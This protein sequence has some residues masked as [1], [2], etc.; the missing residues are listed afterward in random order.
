MGILV[1][2]QSRERIIVD[3]SRELGSMKKAVVRIL[4][5]KV[6]LA[7]LSTDRNPSP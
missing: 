4:L 2:N 1:D 7:N 6:A 3:R 5:A